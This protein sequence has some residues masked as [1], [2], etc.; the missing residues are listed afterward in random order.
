MIHLEYQEGYS[1][2]STAT[3]MNDVRI[4]E[5]YNNLWNSKLCAG[6]FFRKI[7]ESEKIDKIQQ[8]QTKEDE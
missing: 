8:T 2:I 5:I 1:G 7:E 4:M 6:M 3:M